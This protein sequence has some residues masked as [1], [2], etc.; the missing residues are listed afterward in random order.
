V[1][2]SPPIADASVAASFVAASSPQLTSVP[3]VPTRESNF[4]AA[5][6]PTRSARAPAEAVAIVRPAWEASKSQTTDTGWIEANS[7]S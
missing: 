6:P 3:N 7:S 5:A 2:D 1:N 4:G